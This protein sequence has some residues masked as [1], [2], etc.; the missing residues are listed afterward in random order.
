MKRKGRYEVSSRVAP[1]VFCLLPTALLRKPRPV[2]T[3]HDER[4]D[5]FR[6]FEVAAK[7]I[8]LDEPEL[9][10]S[11]IWISS[12]VAEVLHHHKHLVALGAYKTFVLGNAP[13]HARAGLSASSQ[14]TH[15]RVALDG[16]EAHSRMR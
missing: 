12:Q 4:L 5:H 13:Q 8:Q 15:Q 9:V 11:R 2:F 14:T 3:R 1:L 7:L 6:A 10:A 16:R